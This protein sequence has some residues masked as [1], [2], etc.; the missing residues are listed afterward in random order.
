[1]LFE[2]SVVFS[3][4]LAALFQLQ[5]ATFTASLVPSPH[6]RGYFSKCGFFCAF[7]SFV[8]KETASG[9]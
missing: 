6:T 1:M 5:R 3:S 7:W 2:V 4:N 9:N 8:H